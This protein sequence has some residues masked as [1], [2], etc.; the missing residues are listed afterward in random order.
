MK[1]GLLIGRFQPFH[2]GHLYLIKKSLETVDQLVIGIGSAS[3]FDENNPL[4][5]EQRRIIL[6]KVIEKENLKER[7]IKIVDLEDFFNDEKWL[8]NVKKK[9]G[10]FDLVIGN[11]EW[12]NKIMEN[13]SYLVKRI[14]YYKRY[15]Y[16]GWR[17]R[18]LI[19]RSLNWH[20]RVPSYLINDLENFFQKKQYVFNNLALG[21]TFDHFHLGHKKFLE[22]AFQ[23]SKKVLIGITSDD[24]VKNKFLSLTIE[25]YNL[26]KKQIEDFLIRKKYYQRAKIIKINNFTG[27][28]DKNS[29]IEAVFVSKNTYENSLR[30]NE[31]R[32]KNQLKK[33]RIVL[34]K[35][36]LADDGKIIS[37]ERIRAGE[38][39]RK[40]RNYQ[41]GVV[42]YLDRKKEEIFMP[43][44]LR[45]EL[46]KPLGKVFKTTNQVVR[47]IKSTKPLMVIA[48]G[49]VIVDS[50]LKSGIDPNIKIIDFRSQK[51]LYQYQGSDPDKGPTLINKPATINLKTSEIIKIF[52]KN[53]LVN[54]G[55]IYNNWIVIDGEEDLLTLPAILFAPLG[56][57][58]LYG[59]W[60]Y[61]AIGIY[62]NEKAK[63][64]S[65][66]LLNQFKT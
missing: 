31:L 17:I 13:A 21:G 61:G 48:V 5:Y 32:K 59:H 37:S 51:K 2:F 26:R 63:N 18:R 47:Y 55:K 41:L 64:K 27:G 29:K 25:S 8:T 35:E 43:E 44:S 9:A 4:S 40:G 36:V 1:I 52:I 53:F 7:I 23:L 15:L 46:R 33:L 19:N 3:I 62:V 12:I 54:K 28:V 6:K 56:S 60:Q 11:N 30:L 10:R 38:I 65:K 16:E 34:F 20:Q 66:F 42:S 22:K 14:S 24:F 50:L 39:D 45:K 58:V 49:D 57:L